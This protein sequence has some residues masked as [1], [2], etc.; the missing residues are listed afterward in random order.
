MGQLLLLNG[1]SLWVYLWV[2]QHK[3]LMLNA[4]SIGSNPASRI[5][6]TGKQKTVTPAILPH[7][8]LKDGAKH[9]HWWLFVW[10]YPV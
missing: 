3:L 5:Y 4:V 10:F 6:A 1:I 8:V 9:Y 7:G 2:N